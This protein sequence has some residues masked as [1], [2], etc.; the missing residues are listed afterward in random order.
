MSLVSIIMPYYKKINFIE[1]TYYSIINQTY[2]NYE[3]L[4]IYDDLDLSEYENLIKLTKNNKKVRIFKN[5][6]NIGAGLSRNLGIKN[7]KGEYISFIDADDIWNKD[8]LS[9]Q[10]KFMKKNNYFFSYT[11]Y[12][13]QYKN[14]IIEVRAKNEINYNDILKSCEI[15]LSSVILKKI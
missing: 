3:L 5:K 6:K 7:S 13:K 14:K 10:I 1:K 12:S 9:A 8:K 11:N 15:G 4:I 2:E